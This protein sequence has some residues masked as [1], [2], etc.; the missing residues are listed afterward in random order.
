MFSMFPIT[1]IILSFILGA[2]L[3]EFYGLSVIYI[4]IGGFT[5]DIDHLFVYW[6]ETKKY[7]LNLLKAYDYFA[8]HK[9]N[10]QNRNVLFIFHTAEFLVLLFLLGFFNKIFFLI[11]L[12]LLFHLVLDAIQEMRIFGRLIKHPS[13]IVWLFKKNIF[14]KKV[15]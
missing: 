3:Y 4:I 11:S 14:T 8:S 7:T 1:H 9:L 12:G 2:F 15:F 13:F 6:K 5:F 10:I